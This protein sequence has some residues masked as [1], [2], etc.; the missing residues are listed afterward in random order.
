VAIAVMARLMACCWL[1]P[2]P[3]RPQFKLTRPP[4][5]SDWTV[6]S[7]IVWVEVGWPV[8]PLWSACV[9][10]PDSVQTVFS[11]IEACV[12]TYALPETA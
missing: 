7:A 5:E 3:L 10:S 12:K 6:S 4:P 8:A 9:P 1:V 2:L 11:A